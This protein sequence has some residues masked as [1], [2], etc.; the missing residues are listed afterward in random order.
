MLFLLAPL[1]VFHVNEFPHVACHDVISH[2][3]G[4]TSGTQL[5]VQ[6]HSL[7]RMVLAEQALGVLSIVL[8][9]IFAE[10]PPHF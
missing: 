1:L 5:D 8:D 6:N 3:L 9:L 2:C 10:V 4:G 7:D